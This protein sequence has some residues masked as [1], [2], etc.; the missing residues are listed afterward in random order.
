[1]VTKKPSQKVLVEIIRRI[2]AVAR[3]E[4][5]IL[6]GSAARGRMD[7]NSDIDLLVIKR[8]AY[9]PRKVAADIYMHLYGVGQAVELIIMTPEQIDQYRNSPYIVVYPALREGKV[10]YDAGK[11]PA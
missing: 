6:F 8:G 10:L 4:R 7:R 2:V 1:M 11:V 9:N 5:I 3:P